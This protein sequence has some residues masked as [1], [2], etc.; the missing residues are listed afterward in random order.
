MGTIE[1]RV[2]PR[3]AKP[4]V[5]LR[6]GRVVIRVQAPPVGGRATDE[7]RRRLAE[8]LAV[9]PSAVRLR[10]GAASRDKTFEVDGVAR[11]ELL[12]RLPGGR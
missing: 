9:P 10:S 3:S 2:T 1:V 12:R 7:A 11:E 5:E 8:A 6:E 4:G